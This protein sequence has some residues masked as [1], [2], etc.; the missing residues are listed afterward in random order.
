MRY[1]SDGLKV[2][3]TEVVKAGDLTSEG[4][5]T[6]EEAVEAET[7]ITDSIMGITNFA[8]AFMDMLTTVDGI[9]G[10]LLP[11]YLHD[12]GRKK[13]TAKHTIIESKEET[14]APAEPAAGPPAP[15]DAGQISELLDNVIEGEG[16]IKLS[17]LKAKIKDG[18]ILKYVNELI[19]E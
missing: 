2:P 5:H 12:K 3:T 7:S 1:T 16:D 17:E 14:G 11:V 10:A 13:A 8:K 6:A 15:E 18:S 4:G 19:A 9:V